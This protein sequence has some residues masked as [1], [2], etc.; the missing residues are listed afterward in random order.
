VYANAF[1]NFS[2]TSIKKEL[3]WGFDIKTF[4]DNTVFFAEKEKALLD[5]LYIHNKKNLDNG[6][7]IEFYRLQNLQSLNKN[8][9]ITYCKQ[10]ENKKMEALLHQVLNLSDPDWKVL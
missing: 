10:F 9:L 1:G 2:Y 5:L 4:G 3:F 7:I 6:N 8:K